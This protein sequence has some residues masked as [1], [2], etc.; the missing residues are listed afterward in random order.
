M[1]ERVESCFLKKKKNIHLDPSICFVLNNPLI[2]QMP[3]EEMDT[4]EDLQPPVLERS[5]PLPVTDMGP[6]VLQ[7]SVS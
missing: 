7:H 3:V 2:T 5:V 6:P 4:T 1:N